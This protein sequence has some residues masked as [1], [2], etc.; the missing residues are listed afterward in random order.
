MS[1]KSV[2]ILMGNSLVP[3]E[4][5]DDSDEAY[6]EA[7]EDAIYSS[8]SIDIIDLV[9]KDDFKYSYQLLID[10]IKNRPIE[11]QQQFIKEMLDKI[12]EVYD[13]KFP[14]RIEFDLQEEINNFY[15]FFKFLEFDNLHFISNVWKFLEQNLLQID[16]MDYCKENKEKIISEIEEQLDI[17]PQNETITIFLRTYYKVHY[18]FGL[19][20][21]GHKVEIMVNI[22]ESEGKL[23]G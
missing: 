4:E 13:F 1:E 14:Y 12:S 5:V 3:P 9:G 16:L 2:R 20:S 19:K 22:F 6:F 15:D 18:W 17:Y 8:S 23:N 21:F 7:T 11:D 10:D